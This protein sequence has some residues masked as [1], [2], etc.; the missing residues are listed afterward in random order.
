MPAASPDAIVCAS[1]GQIDR[2]LGEILE[3]A[4]V[5]PTMIVG[6]PSATTSSRPRWQ[7]RSPT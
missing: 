7:L 4:D 1:D 3:M 6:A 2:T 5:P